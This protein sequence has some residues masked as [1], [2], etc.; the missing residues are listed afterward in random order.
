MTYE[1]NHREFFFEISVIGV[2][3]PTKFEELFDMLFGHDEWVCNSDILYNCSA[4]DVSHL[5]VFEMKEVIHLCEKWRMRVG[6][7]K[8]GMVVPEVEQYVFARMYMRRVLFKWDAEIEAF[9]TRAAAI[10][11]LL[12]DASTQYMYCENHLPK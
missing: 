5:T 4:L 3:D 8:C 2:L 12:D 6:R 1:I 7:G 10:H 9:R 11:W